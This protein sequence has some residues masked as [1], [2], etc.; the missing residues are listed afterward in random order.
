MAFSI[1]VGGED[2]PYNRN[3]EARKYISCLNQL[4][5]N[6]GGFQQQSRVHLCE[7]IQ[8]VKDGKLEEAIKTFESATD[9]LIRPEPYLFISV[10]LIQRGLASGASS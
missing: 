3:N 6:Y 10:I 7:G 5:N 1:Q 4:Q 2:S 9:F 8:C